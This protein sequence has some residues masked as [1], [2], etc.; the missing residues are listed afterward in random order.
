MPMSPL[1]SEQRALK[2]AQIADLEQAYPDPREP[3][4]KGTIERLSA[5][6]AA[7]PEVAQDAPMAAASPEHL[8]ARIRDL[9][10]E[11]GEM[12]TRLEASDAERATLAARLAA[13]AE[14]ALPSSPLVA[15]H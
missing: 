3:F 6:V 15:A 7:A 11:V 13:V 14:A 5:E 4:V 2:V 9:E 12:R 10:T 1:T 8:Y